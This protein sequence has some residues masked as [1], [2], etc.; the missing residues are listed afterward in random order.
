MGNLPFCLASLQEEQSP[1][2]T[3][4]LMPCPDTLLPLTPGRFWLCKENRIWKE[5]MDFLWH[6]G[7]CSPR[8][9]PEQRSRHFGRLLVP[10]NP[11][12]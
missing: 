11:D 6:P 5:N 9:H 3:F 12:V 10:G 1:W 7:V 8:D 4:F 2:L